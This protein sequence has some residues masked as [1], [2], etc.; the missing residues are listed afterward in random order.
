MKQYSQSISQFFSD[1][2]NNVHKDADRTAFQVITFGYNLKVW[3]TRESMAR[4]IRKQQK[5][6]PHYTDYHPLI[7]LKDGEGY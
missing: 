1:K 7:P 6:T 3:P 2:K 5:R 4:S